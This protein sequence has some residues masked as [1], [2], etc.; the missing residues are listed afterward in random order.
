MAVAPRYHSGSGG[1]FGSRNGDL[2]VDDCLG[3]LELCGYGLRLYS[4]LLGYKGVFGAFFGSERW[5]Y[6]VLM[7]GWLENASSV[8]LGG[9][10]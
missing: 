2:G 3:S 7:S 9:L 6:L 5:T 10:Y 8:V 1:G 4:E